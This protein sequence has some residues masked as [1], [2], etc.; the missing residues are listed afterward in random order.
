MDWIAEKAS[1]TLA[2]TGRLTVVVQDN[3][4]AHTSRLAQQQWLKW[5]AQGLFLFWLPPYCS[6]MNRIEEQWH[7][8]K[9]HEIAGRM[10]EHEVDLADAIIEGMQARSSRGNYSLER[11]IFNSS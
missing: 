11:F 2:Q 7:Q 9:T 4:S 1:V 10:F 6:E 3:G 8:L 5:Q